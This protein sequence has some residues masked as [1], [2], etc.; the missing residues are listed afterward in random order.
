M[1]KSSMV[2]VVV[3][4]FAVPLMAQDI[5]VAKLRETNAAN[6][7]GIKPA[8]TP[9]SLLDLSRIRWS[10]SYSVSFMSGAGGSGSVGLLNSTMFYE[11]SPK[12]SMA[13]N[14]GIMHNAGAIWGD[15][16]N[17]ATLLPGFQLDYHPSDKFSLSIGVS[18]EAGWL[19]PYYYA[20]YSRYPYG[21]WRFP[22]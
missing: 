8:S 10:N 2:I 1:K 22:Y 16:N 17:Q 20:P 15:A 4:L 3:L 5:D 19:S 9:F 18:R 14:I 11:F 7:L 13:L 21:N 12:L 6:S